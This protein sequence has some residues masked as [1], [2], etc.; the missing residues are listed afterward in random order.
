MV[1]ELIQAAQTE[2]DNHS[3]YVCGYQN[4]VT[5]EEVPVRWREK[6][7]DALAENP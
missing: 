3:I 6:V 2:V 1:S 5:L 4:G 7:R